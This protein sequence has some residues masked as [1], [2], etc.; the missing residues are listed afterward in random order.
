MARLIFAMEEKNR[1]VHRHAAG[2]ATA[3]TCALKK[4][5]DMIGMNPAMSALL[6]PDLMAEVIAARPIAVMASA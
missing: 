6:L 1:I 4:R 3:K 5:D 2:N